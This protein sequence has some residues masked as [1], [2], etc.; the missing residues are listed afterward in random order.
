V[1]VYKDS[2]LNGNGQ[3]ILPFAPALST[4]QITGIGTESAV[5][6]GNIVP[7]GG[8]TITARGVVWNTLPAP[9]IDLSTKTMDGSG[10]GAFTSNLTGL[11]PNT[12]YYVRAYATNSVGTSYGE[13]RSFTTLTPATVAAIS[14]GTVSDIT[15]NSASTANTIS[16]DGG[17]NVTERGVVWNTL[18]APTIDL[19]TKTMDGSGT[20]AFSSNLTGLQP[21]T[22]YYVRAYATNSVGTSY[23]EER[24]FTTLFVGIEDLETQKKIRIF[25]NPVTNGLLHVEFGTP[26]SL[27]LF[28]ARGRMMLEETQISGTKTIAVSLKPGFYFAKV[29]TEIGSQTVK[30]VVE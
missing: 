21:N 23:G 8:P 17:A 16:T 26:G 3:I 29:Q 27:T 11:Q 10:T 13:E 19:T 28:D 2:T 18:P 12:L 30:L 15:T 14:T 9:T 20:G 4:L 25:P 6:G 7:N 24:S 5:A 22:L 1:I